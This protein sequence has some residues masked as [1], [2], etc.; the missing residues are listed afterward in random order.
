MRKL[1]GIISAFMALILFLF[2]TGL[3]GS[4]PLTETINTIPEGRIE[5]TLLEEFPRLNECYRMETYM[6][7][8]GIQPYLS[9]WY[10]FNYLHKG[11]PES[12][13]NA[14]GDSFFRVWIYSGDYFKGLLHTGFMILFRIPTGSDAYVDDTWRN[15]SFGNNELK[16]GPVVQ[17][18][19]KE[20]VFLHINLFYIFR[21]GSDGFY[22]GFYID[23]FEKETY[24]KLFGLNFQSEDTFFAKERLKNDYFNVSFAVN[25]DIVY[26]VII[27]IEFFHSRRIYNKDYKE[28]DLPIEGAGI[29]PLLLSAGS[30]YFFTNNMFFG[31]Y[32]VIN[33][34]REKNYIKDIIGFDFSL[35]F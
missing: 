9:I 35:Q 16:T 23:P 3:K 2:S 19:I 21:Q 1:P 11:F 30:R 26:P 28:K 18:D 8:I 27:Y 15:L 25:T 32:Y 33:P 7:G 14:M 13:K 29:N 12:D 31:F 6:L 17:L 5:F 10:S 34:L 24:T 20:S 4:L 22:N